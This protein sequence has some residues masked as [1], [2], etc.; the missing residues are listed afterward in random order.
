MPLPA[1]IGRQ[2][3]FDVVAVMIAL[4]GHHRNSNQATRIDVERRLAAE[5][6]R[7]RSKSELRGGWIEINIKFRDINDGMVEIGRRKFGERVFERR[8][9][10]DKIGGDF[11]G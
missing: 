5:L 8:V 2:H 6:R 3:I 11:L 1:T 9:Y 7:Q 10:D 4:G